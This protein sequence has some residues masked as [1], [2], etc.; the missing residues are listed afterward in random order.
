MPLLIDD[1]ELLAGLT[2]LLAHVDR[3]TDAG[4]AIGAAGMEADM[5]AT[6]AH[7]DQSGATRDSYTAYVVGPN[8]DGSA[9]AAEGYSAAAAALTG[10]TGHAGKA[11]KED[12]GV[13]LGEGEK[14]IIL[15]AFTDYQDRLE[16]DNAGEKAVL[17]PTLQADA[18]AVTGLVA[19]AL[20]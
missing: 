5:K 3:G 17:G 20:R 2:G 15:T 12:S 6:Q 14:G 11:L 13:V 9:E 18:E 16:I 19:T 7:G 1:S 10:F 8:R 4:L